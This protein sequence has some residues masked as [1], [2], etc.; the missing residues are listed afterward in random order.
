MRVAR[1]AIFVSLSSAVVCSVASLAVAQVTT[2]NVRGTVRGADD[3]VP[4][5][6]VEV[7][8]VD[9]ST[10]AEKATTTNEEGGFA[11]NGLQVGGPYRVT[12]NL[13]GFK[14]SEEQGIYLS[15]NRTRDVALGM[16]LQEEVIEVSGS[17]LARNTSSKTVITAAE[18]ESLPS[19]GRDPRDVIRRNPEASVEGANKTLTIG[20]NNNRFNSITVDGTRQDDDFGLNASGYPTRRSPIALSAIQELTVDSSPFDVHFGKFLGG[21]VNIITKSGTNEFKGTLVGTYS[22]NTLRG[23]KSRDNRIRGDFNEYRYGAT[24]SGPLA[25]DEM[26][27]LLSFE[28]LASTTPISVGPADSGA[29]TTVTGVTPADMQRAIEIARDVYGFT[30][31]AP[32]GSLDEGDMKILGK[33]DWNIDKQNRAS[34]IYQR[35]SGNSIQLGNGASTTTLPLSSNW[36]NARDA[37]NTFATRVYSDWSDRLS[38]TLEANAKIVSSR[39]PPVNGNNFMQASVR[40]MTGG[41]IILGPDRFRHSNLLD[42]DVYHARGEA[43]YLMGSHLLTGGIDYEQLRIKNLFVS[44]S[45]GNVVYNNLDDFMNMRPASIQYQNSV[46]L[47]PRDAAANWNLGTWTGYVQDQFKLTSELTVQGG[48]RAEVYQTSNKSSLNSNFVEKY[49]FSNTE[50]LSGRTA[51]LPRLGV[52]WLPLNN[53]NIRAGA[54]LYSGGTPGVWVSNNYTNDGVRTFSVTS[55]DAAVINGFNGRDIP[56]ALQT[57]VQNGAGNGNVDALDPDFKIPSVWKASA[58]AD[59]AL[60]LGPIENIELRGNYTF[61]KVNNGILWKDLRRDL[62]SLPNNTPIGTT[63]DGRPLYAPNFN[64]SRGFDMLLT[65]SDRGYG[66]VLS[67][68]VQKGFEFGLFV[69]ASYAYTINKEVSPGTSSIS[70]SNYRL[71]AVVDPQNPPLATSNYE[72]RHRFTETIEFSHPMF[73]HVTSSSLW[74]KLNTSIGMFIETRS[75]QPYSWTFRGDDTGG[76]NGTKMGR[77]FGEE[78]TFAASARELAYIPTLDETC[79]MPA[80]GAPKPAGCKVELQNVDP[81][82]LNRFL[83]YTGLAKYRGQIAPRN[84]FRSPWYTR[85]DMR[86]AQD[87]PNPLS[88][89]RARFVVDIENVGNLINRK[90]G[91]LQQ[92]NF[93]YAVPIIYDVDY[94]RAN[95]AYIFAKP[96]AFRPMNPTV[97]DITQ[98]VWRLSLGL[99][100]DF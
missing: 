63:V 27:F 74:S 72:R 71:A 60:N 81:D 5:A 34:L 91:R 77:I 45:N 30:A 16:R 56:M 88:G 62:D 85:I 17:S 86:V 19:V 84:A 57:A 67:G 92:T 87:L 7:T 42:N 47:N 13:M 68:V 1:L 9:E 22:S 23:T 21:N 79:A 55:R 76:V 2:S 3:G 75:G 36:Y 40:T 12:A 100:Y 94:D 64:V 48:L 95:D 99:M 37:L 61:S 28:G 33:L 50:T 44:D 52:S 49:G 93:P 98:S 65:N 97:V 35:T 90:W 96:R 66:H 83:E 39:V 4:M 59:Y 69:A 78:A 15:A 80:M 51:F 14:S 24:V 18:I 70:T 32:A 38:T 89:N 82:E 31:G 43:N 46:T 11:F 20:G 6:G 26:H 41:T 25:K 58:G 53:L 29:A 73:S 54:G 10:G 8:L